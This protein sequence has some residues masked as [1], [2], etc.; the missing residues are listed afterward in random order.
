MAINFEINKSVQVGDT[1]NA[2]LVRTINILRD[3]GKNPLVTIE[4][5]VTQDGILCGID[6]SIQLLKNITQNPKVEIWAMREGDEIFKDDVVMRI[7]SPYAPFAAY[8]TAITGILSSCIGWASAA[9]ECVDAADGIPVVNFG[10]SNVHPNIVGLMDYSSIVGGCKGCSSILGSRMKNQTPVGGMADSL[11]LIQGNVLDAASSFLSKGEQ[12]VPVVI[13]VGVLGDEVE[14]AVRVASEFPIRGVRIEPPD[15]RGGLTP[16]LIVELRGKLDQIG[17]EEVDI[18]INCDI[19]PADIIDLVNMEDKWLSYKSG[20]NDDFEG[21]EFEFAHCEGGEFSV[22]KPEFEKS[23][24]IIV[25]PS[26]M[27]HR[28][29]PV[30][31]GVR[32]SLVTWFLGP[33]FK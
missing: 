28:V 16:N 27:E 23:G 31:R 15:G 6:E 12:D 9:M 33:P 3:L 17:K 10:A 20:L 29:A 26:F 32:Y 19:T 4:F 30:T 2:D 18:S 14:E 25:F 13:L 24:S 1:S 21:G 7:K 11:V 5:S 22:A 8:Q